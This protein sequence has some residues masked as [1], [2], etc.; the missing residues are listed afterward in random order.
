[1]K[2][3]KV[4]DIVNQ[5]EKS[6]FLK[7]LD[8]LSNEVREKHPKVDSILA[9]NDDQIK[10]IDNENI[11]QLF[12]YL[13]KYYK[14]YLKD[15]FAYNTFQ[16]GLIAEI[17]TRDGNSIM[18]REW[19]ASLY[20]AEIKTLSNTIKSLEKDLISKKNIPI[21]RLR[22]YNTFRKCVKT[23]YFNDETSNR[24]KVITKDEKSILNTLSQ[25]L[26]LSI[27]EVRN[28]YYS[29]V[30]LE[31]HNIDSVINSLKEAGVIFYNKR[32]LNIYIPDE[33][34]FILREIL[35]IEL[36]NMYFRRI[37][38][39]LSNSQLNKIARKHGLDSKLEREAK[40]VQILKAGVSVSSVLL[41]DIHSENSSKSDLKQF[42]ADLIKKLDLSINKLGSTA[43]DRF[44]IM[45]N[46]F[47]ELEREDNIGMSLDGYERLLNDLNRTLPEINQ[48]IRNE[49]EL[50]QENALNIGVVTDYNIKPLDIVYL[51]SP[52]E[53]SSFC[54]INEISTRGNHRKNIITAY[55][56]TENLYLENF[57][58][59]GSRDINA[60][61][62]KGLKIKESELGI[63]FEDLSKKI[64]R[65]LGYNVDER[66][67]KKINSN[68][69]KIDI[70]LNL[71]NNNV[72]II[73]CKTVKDKI[74]NKY[75]AV[76]RQLRSYQAL[77][78]NK[79][80]NNVQTIIVAYD[81]SEDFID[82]CEYDYA[83]NLTLIS[84]SG[85]IRMLEGFK[86]SK[87][88]T[89]PIELFKKGGRMNADRIIKTLLR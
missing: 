37:L 55:R 72:I 40:I 73:E 29:V 57:D 4:L 33:I 10:N 18:S 7:I 76:S 78:N 36:P 38:R 46:H 48:R 61:Q 15:K 68:K 43:E 8:S 14:N 17:I 89:F 70:I 47:R 41:K 87:L 59:I 28:I 44:N 88:E 26:E 82:E 71:D 83:L 49:F 16:F 19:L 85:L 75:S 69:D 77:C 74:Y 81:F 13:R 42:L 24:E 5:I 64:F 65:Q 30:P 35:G 53:L 52:E 66:L 80:Y 67:R 12:N 31:K 56:D 51:F 32:S 50:Q 3:I 62:E 27:D 6:S 34:I 23:A 45:I 21:S 20:S 63:K 86:A 84:A 79:G 22:D 54:Q 25:E 60:L 1:M 58:L 11:T 2:L 39:Q 9:S